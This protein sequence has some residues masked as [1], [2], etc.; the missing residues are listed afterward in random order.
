MKQLLK[1][2]AVIAAVIISAFAQSSNASVHPLPYYSFG[3]H[4]A[5]TE[6]SFSIE[7]NQ[8]GN[9]QVILVSVK[10]PGKKNLNIT[11]KD[12]DG[13]MIDNFF[14]NKR[15]NQIDKIYNFSEADAGIYT[16]VVTD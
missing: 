13:Y 1:P 5:V 14:T 9:E 12:P 16:I 10:N 11:L 15:L 3:K 4:S 8:R 2:A 6:E 7:L